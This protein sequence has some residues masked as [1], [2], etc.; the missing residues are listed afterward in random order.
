MKLDSSKDIT[1]PSWSPFEGLKLYGEKKGGDDPLWPWEEETTLGS[2]IRRGP[3][4]G[5]Y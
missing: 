5:S 4:Q 2:K 3:H 1:S